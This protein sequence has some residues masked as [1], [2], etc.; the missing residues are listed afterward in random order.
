MKIEVLKSKIKRLTIVESNIEYEGSLTLCPLIML[1][2]GLREYQ[3]VDVNNLTNGN[4]D[5]TYILKS[6]IPNMVAI[7]GAL[8]LRHKKDDIIHVN[9]YGIIDENEKFKPIVI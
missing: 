1:K 4:R 2:A 9:A 8:S 6:K 7:N 3:R 5:N